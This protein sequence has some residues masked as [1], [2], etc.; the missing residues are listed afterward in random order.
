MAATSP[1]DVE[2]VEIKDKSS[3]LKIIIH[4]GRNRQV[5]R[6]C[7]T[8]G[9]PVLKLKRTAIGKLTL[10]NLKPGEWKYLSQQEIKLVRGNRNGTQ[11]S[12]KK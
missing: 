7:E 6:M 8:V 9:H 4:E 10:G 11:I 12:T 3:V 1:A 5:K 2:V